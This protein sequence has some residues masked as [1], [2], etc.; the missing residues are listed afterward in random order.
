[1]LADYEIYQPRSVSAQK[2]GQ[3]VILRFAQ[4]PMEWVPRVFLV[5]EIL[6]FAQDDIA[7]LDR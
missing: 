1:M 4:D 6:R 2:A 3:H 5:P 7:E